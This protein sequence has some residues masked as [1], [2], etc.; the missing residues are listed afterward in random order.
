MRILLPVRR[1]LASWNSP[2][3]VSAMKPSATSVN[4]ASD[5]VVW[6]LMMPLTE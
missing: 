5:S 6:W 4:G 1:S 2:P 3:M